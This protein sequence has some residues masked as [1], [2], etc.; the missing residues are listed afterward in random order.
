M[1]EPF[2]SIKDMKW[3]NELTGEQALETVIL[4]AGGD[5]SAEIEQ[6]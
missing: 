6:G 4:F 3:T 5:A 1:E 2:H